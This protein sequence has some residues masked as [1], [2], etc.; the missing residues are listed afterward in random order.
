M[1]GDW[2]T[3]ILWLWSRTRNEYESCFF[4]FSFRP[5]RVI[6]FLVLRDVP[7]NEVLAIWQEVGKLYDD[8]RRHVARM[9]SLRLICVHNDQ[10]KGGGKPRTTN[11][12][13]PKCS[14]SG[15]VRQRTSDKRFERS[16]FC[17]W[18]K[19][20]YTFK[21]HE[22]VV[23]VWA[24]LGMSVMMSWTRQIALA[25]RKTSS[26]NWN[27]MLTFS[28]TFPRLCNVLFVRSQTILSLQQ[29]R[30]PS[31]RLGWRCLF[32][33]LVTWTLDRFLWS[34]RVICRLRKS[35]AFCD[36]LCRPGLA[37]HLFLSRIHWRFFFIEPDLPSV[38]R[39]LI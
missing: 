35:V 25:P 15:S 30:A 18:N 27:K 12:S 26:P 17:P 22:D 16:L 29:E 24:L 2:G 19:R 5:T 13:T 39:Y 23:R 34:S 33:R 1:V 3:S 11:Y 7:W 36:I 32:L 28:D 20:I 14:G 9:K 8:R 4:F 6:V 38:P 21:P 31:K 10:E 37:W